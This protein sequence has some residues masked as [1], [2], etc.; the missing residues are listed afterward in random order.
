MHL[1][2]H[3]SIAGGVENAVLSGHQIGCD[4][5]AMFTK[6]NNQWK[7]KL[8][9][10]E[11]ADR[12]N[13]A[14]AETGIRQ[15]V[16]HTSYLINLASP[17]AALWKKSIAGMEDELKR[18]NLLGIPYL[19][20]HPG[21]HMGK[22]VEWGIQRV[23]DA[24]NRIHEK[25][26]NVRV[27]TLLEHTAGQGNHLGHLFEELAQMRELI[28]EK[29]RIGVCVDSCHLFAAGYDLRKP[30]TYTDVFKRFD[31]TIGIQHIKAWHLNDAKMPLGSRVDR[32]EH[33][34]KGKLGRGAFRNIVNDPR[35]RDLPG[36]LET[37]K[38]PE[39]KE[40]KMNLRVLRSLLDADKRG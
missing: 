18:C 30:E 24:F 16:A 23:A 21:S 28:A 6:N 40:D 38:G 7:A 15:V 5:I 10:Q 13:A 29:K 33:I 3:M 9:T 35:W 36:L 20:L 37:E 2:A 34:G 27:M 1:G 22:G 25:L 8:L 39:L 17:D 11:D 32:H 31:D 26:P 12:F 19:V 4:A 14:L